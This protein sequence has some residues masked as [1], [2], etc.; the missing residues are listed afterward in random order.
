VYGDFN[1]DGYTDEA[2]GIPGATVNGF[3]NAGA[4]V[5]LYGSAHGLTSQNSLYLTESAAGHSTSQSGP[6]YEFGYSLAV[7]DFNGDGYADL[8]VGAPFDHVG[9]VPDAGQLFIFYGS[10]SGL[11]LAGN[12]L[13][14]LQDPG[15]PHF[16]AKHDHFAYSLASGDFN[17]D[18]YADLAIGSPGQTP[19]PP[20]TFKDI[21]GGGT[22]FV[23]YGGPAGIRIDGMHAW[24]PTTYGILGTEQTNEH[25]GW[26]VTVGDFNGDGYMD[27]ATSAPFKPI[28]TNQS[29]LN[30]GGISILYGGPA[31]IT[32]LGNQYFDETDP[33]LG[34]LA[35]AGTGDLFGYTLSAGDFNG[36]GYWD[37][38]VGIPGAA[39]TNGIANAG[40]VDILY[41][42]ATGLTTQ[43]AQRLTQASLGG[44]DQAGSGFGTVLATGDFHGN[45]MA[46]LAIGVPGETVNGLA[47]AGA[48]YVVS[49]SSLGLST[50]GAQFWT[51]NNIGRGAQARVGDGFGGS[52]GV[53]DFNGDGTTDLVI[54]VPNRTVGGI[55]GAGA[56]DVLF[57][58]A[59]AGLTA[60]GYEYWTENR[61]F[62]KGS[63]AT[64]DAHFGGSFG[65]P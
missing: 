17:G 40:A 60:T 10:A 52:L 18:G 30:G 9:K 31:G 2:I 28:G 25:F 26:V 42:T 48:V 62:G 37:L 33:N 21:F 16:S 19:N 1:H 12:Q 57:G 3:A 23:M 45:G 11:T 65:T 53:G 43:G 6:G 49:G 15:T 20:P 50:V 63:L 13:W 7:G 38:A 4:V 34:H 27:I 41:G 24:D 35:A 47:N 22:I 61:I 39:G 8:A 5:I 46:D 55:V 36:D 14:N 56:E 58:S 29:I 59:S 44:T 54:G 64:A 32:A 51:E